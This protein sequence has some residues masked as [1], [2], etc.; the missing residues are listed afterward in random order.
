LSIECL[1]YPG[2]SARDLLRSPAG[3][4]RLASAVE[5]S[6]IVIGLLD[7]EKIARTMSEGSN[8]GLQRDLIDTFRFC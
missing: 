3:A 8:H 2:E 7:G 1:D 6:D 5:K 4:A